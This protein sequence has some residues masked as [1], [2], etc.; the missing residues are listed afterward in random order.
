M[1]LELTMQIYIFASGITLIFNSLSS[2]SSWFY[3]KSKAKYIVIAQSFAYSLTFII[4]ICLIIANYGLFSF[5]LVYVGETA[6]TIIYEWIIFFKLEGNHFLKLKTVA[7]IQ[8]VRNLFV[9]GWPIIFGSVA[10]MIYL[11]SDQIMIGQILNNHELGIY[12]VAVKLAEVWYFVPSAIATAVMPHLTNLKLSDSKAFEKCLQKYMSI[13]VGFG[14]LIGVLMSLFSQPLILILYG[15]E[16]IEAS[17]ILCVYIWAGVFINMSVLRGQYYVI[18]EITEYS[19]WT[20][21]IGAL[22]NILLNL[23]LIPIIG[24]IGAAIATCISYALYAYFSSFLFPKLHDIGKI[25]TKSLFLKGLWEK[26]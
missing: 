7:I 12:S 10:N 16:Y 17:Q 8:E 5:I 24:G 4:K 11:K 22:T 20:N 2:V 26:L 13:F 23:L 1:K 18:M 15:S 19:M 21:L 14:Y 6:L 25:E 9:Q 3:S